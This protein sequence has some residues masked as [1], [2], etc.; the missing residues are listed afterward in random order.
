[1]TGYSV[2]EVIGRNCRFL[3]G[4]DRDQKARVAMKEATEKGE[5]CK[6]EIRNYTKSGT[7]FWSEVILSPVKDEKGLLTNYIGVQT[8]ITRRKEAEIALSMAEQEKHGANQGNTGLV[9]NESFLASIIETIREGLIV[10]DENIRILSVNDHFCEFFKLNKQ[11]VVGKPLPEMGNGAWNNPAL[12]T[13]LKDVLPLNNPFEGFE[14]TLNFPAIGKKVLKM[15]ARQVTLNGQYLKRTL[16]AIED[17]TQRRE[18]EQRKD[19]FISLASHEMK[20]PLTNIK[21]HMQLLKRMAAKNGDKPY[22]K[23]L[24]VAL[25]SVNRLESLVA[26]LLDADQLKSGAVQFTHHSFDFDELVKEA[27]EAAQ[28][29]TKTHHIH[30]SGLA[31]KVIKGDFFRLEQAVINLLENAVRYSPQSQEVGLHVN[32]LEDYIKVAITDTGIG[33]NQWEQKKIF[34]RFYRVENVK[35]HFQG[36]GIGLYV[37]NENIKQHQGTLWVESEEGRGSVFNFTIPVEK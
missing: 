13:M 23:P 16:L 14:I 19:D 28:G 1:M 3:Q 8:N 32:V 5:Y 22:L 27:A 21:G 24:D 33:I 7:L 34:E 31:N 26:V 37:A 36:I 18:V 12:I 6:V 29:A 11:E 17:I 10:L 4:D 2:Q 25:N 35:Q 20:T 9:E 15:N 30:V